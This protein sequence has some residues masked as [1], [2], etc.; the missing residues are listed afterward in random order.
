MEDFLSISALIPLIV[1]IFAVAVSS[2][3]VKSRI[4]AERHFISAVR[5]Q[6]DD[7][8]IEVPAKTKIFSTSQG[9]SEGPL[10]DPELLSDWKVADGHGA[11]TIVLKNG[12]DHSVYRMPPSS[13]LE[14][15]E[16]RKKYKLIYGALLRS[17]LDGASEFSLVK[18][19]L[20]TLNESDRKKIESTLE[21][22]TSTGRRRYLATVFR[23]AMKTAH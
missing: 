18:D 9:G 11:V 21:N 3:K 20:H 13:T 19:A 14:K 1:S 15:E 4:T 2:F 16:L 8:V 22:N 7:S 5:S 6:I 10:P 23:D 17:S 12:D